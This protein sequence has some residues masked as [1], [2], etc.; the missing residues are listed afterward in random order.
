MILINEANKTYFINGAMLGDSSRSNSIT[1]YP[2]IEGT[3]FSDHSYREPELVRFQMKSSEVSKSLV[4]LVEVDVAGGRIERNLSPRE[5]E[6]LIVHWF[7]DVP[8]L[9]ISTLRF[10]FSNM[11]LQSYSWSDQD[12]SL[13]QPTLSFKEAR[14][15]TLR[16]GVVDNP[17]Q[18]YQ[19]AYGEIISVG[20][21]ASVETSFNIGTA[22]SSAGWGAAAGAA[23]GSVIPGL[24]TA[25]GAVIGGCIGFFGSIFGSL[26]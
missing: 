5:V 13:F 18:Y 14:V 10:T 12:I 16:L 15:Q 7:K 9:E 4:Y 6:E 22:L 19:A 25:A 3:S 1:S 26:F 8:R 17:D 24:G 20:G 21:A 2:T 11:I 23:V